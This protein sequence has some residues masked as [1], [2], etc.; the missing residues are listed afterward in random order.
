MPTYQSLAGQL[1]G[2][3]K[4]PG[5]RTRQLHWPTVANAALATIMKGMYQQKSSTLE[6]LALE[7]RYADEF[8]RTVSPKLFHESAQWGYAVATAICQWS[9]T[10]G[11]DKYHNCE[12]TPPV[13]VGLWVPTPP[14]YAAPLEPC[15][16]RMRTF[17]VTSAS[18]CDPGPHPAYSES[19]GSAFHAEGKE[20]Y[21]TVLNITSEQLTIARF[22]SDDPGATG[23]PPGHSMSIAGQPHR[24]NIQSRS[25]GNRSKDRSHRPRTQ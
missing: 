7:R 18:V 11:F 17:A 23:T 19:P 9:K 10:D 20:V 12:Y 25:R 22:W 3:A 24:S 16:G 13:G 5:P 15:W 8:K 2:L 6:I 21:E 1:N 4:I 14:A